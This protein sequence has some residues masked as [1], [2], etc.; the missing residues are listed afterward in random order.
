MKRNK[1]TRTFPQRPPQR[2]EVWEN[3]GSFFAEFWLTD[4]KT[5]RSYR[6]DQKIPAKVAANWAQE[7]RDKGILDPIEA[8][9]MCE[10]LISNFGRR[11]IIPEKGI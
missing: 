9:M 2:F 10:C 4:H 1:S 5:K 6:Y 11:P 3:E 8:R 7:L